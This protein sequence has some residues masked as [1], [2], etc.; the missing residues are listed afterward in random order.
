[1]ISNNSR[2]G[3]EF[4]EPPTTSRWP[5]HYRRPHNDPPAYHY[6]VHGSFARFLRRYSFSVFARK[7]GAMPIRDDIA[8]TTRRRSPYNDDVMVPLFVGA[9]RVYMGA[10]RS[11]IADGHPDARTIPGLVNGDLRAPFSHAHAAP[12]LRRPRMAA[13]PPNQAARMMWRNSGICR[14]ACAVL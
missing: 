10:Q 4:K 6:K 9:R 5:T 2:A 8:P 13:I 7:A 3:N 1:M 12:F 14:S 11:G